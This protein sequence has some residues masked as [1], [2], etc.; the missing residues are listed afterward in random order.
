M[1]VVAPNRSVASRR[2]LANVLRAGKHF[3]V[4]Y[5][6]SFQIFK[7][8]I[9]PNCKFERQTHDTSSM[10]LNSCL[11][12]LEVSFV[13]D[14]VNINM[15]WKVESVISWPSEAEHNDWAGSCKSLNRLECVFLCLLLRACETLNVIA[16]LLTNDCKERFVNLK[17]DLIS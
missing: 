5:H 6:M 14:L 9:R 12:M 2:H 3:G 4:N 15:T 11:D 17:V 13:L 16:L 10:L 1:S 8:H 7:P